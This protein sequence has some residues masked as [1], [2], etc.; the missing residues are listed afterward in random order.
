MTEKSLKI[1]MVDVFL[2]VA[3]II[4]LLITTLAI[5]L[6]CKHKKLRT[7]VTSLGLQQVR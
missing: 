2:F 5:Y 7:F 4:S 1:F 3:A 6:L